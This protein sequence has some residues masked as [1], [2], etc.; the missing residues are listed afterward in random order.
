MDRF[1][2]EV[3]AGGGST[4]IVS[5]VLNPVDVVKTRRQLEAFRSTTATEIVKSIYREGGV[6]ALWRPGLVASCSRE[7]VY[8]GCTKGLYPHVRSML[9]GGD[10]AEPTLP[11]RVAAASCTGFLG[12]IGANAFDVVK[13]RQFATGASDGLASAMLDVIR[14]EGL[15]RGLLLRG[16]S[17]SAPRGAA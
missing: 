2:R 11:V 16:A 9:A 17:A 10:T 12:S 6:I 13:I 7:L 8:S 4:A 3:A 14:T 15:V 1:V 5:A